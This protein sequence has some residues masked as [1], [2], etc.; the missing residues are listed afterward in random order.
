MHPIKELVGI[1]HLP[2][3]PECTIQHKPTE[4]CRALWHVRIIPSTCTAP[5][6]TCLACLRI[7]IYPS[8][9]ITILTLSSC[10]IPSLS[11]GALHSALIVRSVYY[12]T[13]SAPTAFYTLTITVDCT[14]CAVCRACLA[15]LTCLVC[16]L[17]RGA[18][19]AGVGVPA[20]D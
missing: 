13:C 18:G 17:S 15:L 2:A 11:A 8:A 4:T 5:N 19:D 9:C 3:S 16:I 14:P 1:T 6:W 12:T 10:G 20:E 7:C